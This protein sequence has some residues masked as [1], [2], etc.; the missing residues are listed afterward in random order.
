MQEPLTFENATLSPRF[1]SSFHSHHVTSASA[2]S[3]FV[4]CACWKHCFLFDLAVISC[5]DTDSGFYNYY[6]PKAGISHK[7][8]AAE[9]QFVIPHLLRLQHG[10]FPAFETLGIELDR[11]EC[12]ENKRSKCFRFIM[13]SSFGHTKV[14][15]VLPSRIILD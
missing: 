15:K 6:Y 5:Y 13:L 8:V 1:D 9:M 14:I 3:A 2:A 12:N 7:V 10:D 4:V 11:S